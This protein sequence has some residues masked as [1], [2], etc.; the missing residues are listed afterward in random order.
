M[1][2]SALLGHGTESFQDQCKRFEAA[3]QAQADVRTKEQ[4]ASTMMQQQRGLESSRRYLAGSP[5]ALCHN[6]EQTPGTVS[7]A[8]AR[9]MQSEKW[10]G[11]RFE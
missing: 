11:F 6:K 1:G 10:H 4:A 2:Y 3:M 8:A 7:P 9:Q 5:Y